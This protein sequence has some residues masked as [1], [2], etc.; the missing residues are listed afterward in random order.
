MYSL[1]RSPAEDPQAVAETSDTSIQMI[2]NKPAQHQ[3]RSLISRRSSTHNFKEAVSCAL[4]QTL[5][6][7]SKLFKSQHEF[8]VSNIMVHSNLLETG[9]TDRSLAMLMYDQY[10]RDPFSNSPRL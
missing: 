8:Y 7:N 5:E 1:D 6:D 9:P 10:V 3:I 4:R 2:S